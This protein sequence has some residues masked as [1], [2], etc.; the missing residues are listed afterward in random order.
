MFGVGHAAVGL[1]VYTDVRLYFL[2]PIAEWPR[3]GFPLRLD[4]FGTANWL[5][6]GAAVVLGLLLATSGDW[7]LRRYGARRWKRVQQLAYW[8]FTLIVVHAILYQR[9]DLHEQGP[10][11][12]ALG[13]IVASVI[14]VQT[15]GFLKAGR[16]LVH[17]DAR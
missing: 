4:D 17:H 8:A 6:L 12:P 7:A 13:V 14:V 5:G 16:H 2:Y 1:L 11:V 9:L 15:A 3:T 10:L